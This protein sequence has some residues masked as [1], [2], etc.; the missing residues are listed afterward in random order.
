MI[1][2]HL[3][4]FLSAQGICDGRLYPGTLPVAEEIEYPAGTFNEMPSQTER[5]RSGR[6]Q[7]QHPTIQIT[8]FSDK[9]AEA[10][11]ERK[12]LHDLMELYSGPIG[13]VT[14]QIVFYR[15][16]GDI[17][18]PDTGLHGKASEIEVWYD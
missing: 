3:I 6:V 15:F 8:V 10:E 7:L 17:T 16:L 2:E 4:P 13:E 5:S 14:A 12:K 1:V 11:A 9:Y 18:E